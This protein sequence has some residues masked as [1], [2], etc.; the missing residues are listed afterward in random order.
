MVTV[1]GTTFHVST[2][3]EENIP[4]SVLQG[5]I[6]YADK[7]S[8]FTA[9][10]KANEALICDSLHHL[11]VATIQASEQMLWTEGVLY[12]NHET[13]GHAIKKIERWFGVHIRLD[14]P[15]FKQETFKGR[16]K[17]P[18]LAQVLRSICFGLNARYEQTAQ[19]ITI[20]K[21]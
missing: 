20:I 15:Q 17:Q 8:A 2:F 7:R 18:T 21:K 4:V 3:P 5:K 9:V 13:M 16:F 6:R 12:F 10:L 1:L 14:D 11:Q 19:G